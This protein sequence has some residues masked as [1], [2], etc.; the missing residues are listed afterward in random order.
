[1]PESRHKYLYERLGDHDFQQL[2]AAL[3]AAQFPDF[4]PMALRQADGGRDGMRGLGSGNALIYQVKWS[5]SG[6]EKDPVTWLDA[7]VRKEAANLRRLAGEGVRRYMLVTNVPSTSK[8]GTGTYDRLRRKLEEHARAFKF[9]EISCVWREALNPWV[10]NAPTETKWA[11]AEML[12]GWDLIRYLVAEHVGASKDKGLRDL[13]RKIA[14]AQW[15]EDERV[16][17]SQSEVDRE[18][19]VDLFVDVTADRIRA[20]VPAGQYSPPVAAVGGAAEYLLGAA[21]PF[22]LVRG[23]PGQGKSTLSQYVCQVHRSSFVPASARPQSLPAITKPRFPLRFDLSEYA[24]WLGGVDIWDPAEDSKRPMTTRRPGN[25]AT[26]ECFLADLMTHEGG[27]SKVTPSDV[28]DLFTRVPSLV[29]LDGLDEVGSPAI[30]TRVV[31]AIDKFASRGKVYDDPPKVVVT[32]RPSHGELAEPSKDLFEV[33]TLNPLT[34]EQ[35]GDYL[36][37]WCDV[38]GIHGKDGRELRIGF[39]DKSR[40]PYIGELAGNPMQLTILLD[41]L[42]RQGAAT[43][44]QR[45]DLYDQYVDLL[46]AREANKHP[47]VVR[48]HKEE[49]LEI[50]PFLGW[51]LHAHTEESQINGRMTVAD[52][53]EAMRHFQRAYGNPESVVDELFEGATDRLWAL[54][55]KIDG[56]YEFEVLSLREYFAARFLYRNAGED[57]PAFDSTSVLCELLRRPYW[58]NTARFYG[59]NAK[60]S[61]IYVLAAGIE[62]ELADGSAS[63]AFLAAWALLT[64]GVFLR[65]P[66]EARR[67]L[68]ALCADNGLAILLRALEDRDIRALPALP[69]LPDT[70]G[71]D[72][73]WIRLTSEIITDP[74]AG[75]NTWRVQV[76]RELLNQRSQFAAWWARQLREA[77]GTPRQNAWLKLGA[78]CEAAAGTTIDLNH[79]DLT[80]GAAEL[81]LNTGIVPPPGSDLEA[82]LL[83]AVLNGECPRVT[84]I[85]S[86]PARV[87][88]ALAPDSFLA[89]SATGFLDGDDR[90][91]RRRSDAINQLRKAGS[92]FAE[93]ARKRI[94][95]AGQKGSTFPWANTATALVRHAGRCWLASEIAIIGAASPLAL[96]YTKA[97]G[98]TAFGPTG[99]PSELLA[100]SRTHADDATWWR[101]QIA[102]VGDEELGKAE[103]TLALWGVAT[104]EVIDELLPEWERVLDALPRPRRRTVL[105]DADRIARHGW[106]KKRP[107]TTSTARNEL[108]KLI[109]SRTSAPLMPPPGTRHLDQSPQPGGAAPSETVAEPS[110]GSPARSSLLKCARVDKWLKVD[111]LPVYH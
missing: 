48:K 28:Q 6:K 60:G 25:Q 42:H 100:Q 91:R 44:T 30:R 81:L 18:K 79:I 86:F 8:P 77:I 95:K 84:S 90:T 35:R 96:G 58:L 2:V 46:L 65:R 55:S 89:T 67:V 78:D 61:G 93:V 109:A 53:Q 26:I 16:K 108:S 103:W 45:T 49:L 47:E 13:V 80:D 54:T 70:D 98:S 111:S 76:L 51:Y 34:L 24:R 87:A 50:V 64:D 69:G 97:P 39:K 83:R 1:L 110:P 7:V 85:R 57:N 37:K 38:R 33:L 15:D 3:L 19:V 66:R 41:L 68:T 102:A 5:V 59:G 14:S 63:A 105:K 23:A 101:Q 82:D 52:L 88:V 104:G 73:T 43:P 75:G 22:T 40:E 31:E 20:V 99:H 27:G 74:F 29:V 36:R 62:G 11:Y 72:P 12:A 56:T 17:F 94:F 4:V 107:V 106:L 71:P 10:D 32:T 92:P 9:E 21:A